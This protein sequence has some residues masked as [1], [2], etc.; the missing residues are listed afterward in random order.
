MLDSWNDTSGHSVDRRVKK[1]RT[2]CR[3]QVLLAGAA[4]LTPG[5]WADLPPGNDPVV[6]AP[7]TT[8]GTT[9]RNSLTLNA[10]A[11]V[12]QVTQDP[13]TTITL[14]GGFLFKQGT[15]TGQISGGNLRSG[16]DELIV[17]TSGGDLVIASA[18]SNANDALVK[19]GTGTLVLTS[20]SATR[21][22][23]AGGIFLNQGMVRISSDANLG[24]NA[25]N[26]NSLTFQGGGLET[27][28]GLNFGSARTLF[29]DPS[30]GG[31]VRVT[32]GT[33]TIDDANQLRGAGP[34]LKAGAG[35]LLVS[36]ATR[37]SPARSR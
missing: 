29:F 13:D 2:C 26:S 25:G 9:A 35:T 10:S 24:A 21:H 15:F 11:N 16:I 8:T 5:A 17:S 28:A 32:A 7:S 18:L 19:D 31:T 27:T 30:G 1:P 22:V 20:T 23:F 4:G 36:S 3:A 6:S 33:L 12:V 37:R 14:N 34:L